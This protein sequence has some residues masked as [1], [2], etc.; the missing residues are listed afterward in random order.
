MNRFEIQKIIFL[1]LYSSSIT[2]ILIQKLNF[3]FH[4]RGPYSEIIQ[5]AIES[6]VLEGYVKI[7]FTRKYFKTTHEDYSLTE[8][9]LTKLE[10]MIDQH[11]QYD[12][13]F[14]VS[15][16]ICHGID[17]AGW[18]NFIKIVYALSDIK[19]MKW[20]DIEL[21]DKIMY[22]ET[23]IQKLSS[24]LKD[25]FENSFLNSISKSDFYYV[26]ALVLVEHLFSIVNFESARYQG[27]GFDAKIKSLT[28]G[29]I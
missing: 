5:M 25:Y 24:K 2:E 10:K 22:G 15:K 11:E 21:S 13:L 3:Y 16:G 29:I 8:R 23:T 6:M 9:G 26:V 4:K 19:E 1:T 14:E 12:L 27:I 18:K 7:E 28:E 20:Q 17:F